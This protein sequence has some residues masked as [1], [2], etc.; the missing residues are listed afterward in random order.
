[1]WPGAAVPLTPTRGTTIHNRT[2]HRRVNFS[3]HHQK[4]KALS[5]NRKLRRDCRTA[6]GSFF[7]DQKHKLNTISSVQR[8]AHRPMCLSPTTSDRSHTTS[9]EARRQPHCTRC[10]IFFA[11]TQQQGESLHRTKN[12][13]NRHNAEGQPP[14]V[15]WLK[16]GMTLFS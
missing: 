6:K 13:E 12:K 11:H 2:E 9:S 5:P 10:V 14:V 3:Q 7:T 4:Q 1:M 8:V 16:T 15:R